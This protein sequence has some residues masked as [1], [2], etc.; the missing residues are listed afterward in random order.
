MF[1]IG[2]WDKQKII[3]HYIE[4]ND[5]RKVL[6]I[7][8]ERLKQEYDIPV[9]H[10]YIEYHQTIMYKHYYRLLQWVDKYT[11]I[12][13]DN[14]LMTQQRYQL[15]YNCINNYINQTPHRLVFNYLPFI[16]DKD[17]FM[18]LL[19]FY[20]KNL[21]KGE[22]FRWDYLKD[23]NLFIKPVHLSF[24]FIDTPVSEKDKATY[25]AKKEKMFAE[26]GLRDP[27][28]IPRNLAILAGDL[29]KPNVD[30][31]KK[32]TCRNARCKS[33]STSTYKQNELNT[34]FDF[35]IKRTEFIELLSLTKQTEI[36]VVTSELT[37]DRYYKKDY[38]AW[39][40]RLEEFYDTANI[41]RG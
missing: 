1:Y 8:S 12:I 11:L 4:N 30:P 19:D 22:P 15:E 26:I 6:V 2:N 33:L 37:V 36:D 28:T 23:V 40:D 9:P 24:N 21:Y 32:Y 10:E 27:D 29:R 38:L 14:I 25:E 18:I 16:E 13:T 17:D 3:S 31:A 5:V 39:R 7:H 35:P 34:V 41:L 20:N